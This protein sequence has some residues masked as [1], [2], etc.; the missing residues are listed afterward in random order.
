MSAYISGGSKSGKSMLAQRIARAWAAEGRPLYYV[1]TMLPHDDEDAARIARHRREREGWGFVTLERGR[2]LT[3]C[4]E[5]AD[6]GGVFL[7]DSVTALL[8]NE[9]FPAGGVDMDAPQRVAADLAEFVRRAPETVFVSDF[10]FSDAA[11]YDELTEA[12]RRG[13]AFVDRR[14]ASLCD[15]VIEAAAGRFIIHKGGLPL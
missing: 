14:M 7:V 4:L 6:A 10:I 2:D 12:Y 13:L 11:L 5:G 1:A 8:A 9:M 3:G 15:S